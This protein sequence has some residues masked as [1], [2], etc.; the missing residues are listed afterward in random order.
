MSLKH[1]IADQVLR[2]SPPFAVS[3]TAIIGGLTLNQWVAIA[4]LVYIVLQA[5]V[6]IRKEIRSTRDSKLFKERVLEKA[7]DE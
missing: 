3:L 7:G 4:T 5:V 2:A 1:E 6:L